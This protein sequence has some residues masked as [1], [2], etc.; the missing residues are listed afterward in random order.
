MLMTSVNPKADFNSSPVTKVSPSYKYY[1]AFFRISN[2][3]FSVS[4]DMKTEKKAFAYSV[5]QS[6]RHPN[7]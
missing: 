4:T 3:F 1:Q 6:S 7:H 2:F 5:T